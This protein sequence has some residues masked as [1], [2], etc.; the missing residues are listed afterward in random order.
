M[1]D[2][3][4]TPDQT[5]PAK[6]D[7]YKSFMKSVDLP[8]GAEVQAKEQKLFEEH[9]VTRQPFLDKDKE[10]T[11]KMNALNEEMANIKPPAKP[12][13]EKLPD[14]PDTQ[15]QD[16]IKAMGSVGSLIAILGS[17][18]TRAPMT[19][20][21]NAAAA[22]M[23]AYHQGDMEAAQLER[24][25]WKD[26]FEKA[27]K[28]NQEE[29]QQYTAA[30]QESQFDITRAQAKL[31]TIAAQQQNNSMLAA[32]EAGDYQAQEKI[33]AGGIS[34]GQKGAELYSK[35]Q[36][37]Q[38]QLEQ[39]AILK[40]MAMGSGKEL[41]QDT[42]DYYATQSLNGDN[43]WQ[44]GLARGKAGQ[45]L[46]QAVKDRIPQMAKELGMRPTDAIANKAELGGLTSALRDREKYVAAGNQF[47]SNFNSQADLVEKYLAPGAAGG[48]P[49]INKWIQAGRQQI[50]GDPDVTALDTAIRGLA[51]EHQR[52]VTGVT[53]NAQLHVSAQETADQLLNKD[54]T[55][56]QVRS[57]LKVMREEATNALA[58]GKG[59]VDALKGQISTPH[60]GQTNAKPQPTEKDI[61]WVKAHPEDADKFKAHFGTSP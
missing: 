2:D 50:A 51:R 58:A 52:I 9:K 44:V 17:L 61:A 48:T 7:R 5:G 34:A 45:Q 3:T 39:N 4:Q 1:A 20:A 8:T 59:E 23:K 27:L 56:E 41:T 29:M 49:I 47:I 22:S 14:A 24:E 19:S 38:A 37:K 42:V 11:E 21:L 60:S 46:I 10:L 40:R 26:N 18:K 53:S 15:M 30:L 43:S 36:E 33:I 28:S 13:Q 6:D 16:P 25:K 57:T 31:R 12:K 54:M 35:H 32:V 55:P